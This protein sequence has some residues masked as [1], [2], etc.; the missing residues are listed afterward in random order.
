MNEKKEQGTKG[1]EKNNESQEGE[2]NVKGPRKPGYFAEKKKK[3]AKEGKRKTFGGVELGNRRARLGSV[4]EHDINQGGKH[5]KPRTEE[6]KMDGYGG[7]QKNLAI[8]GLVDRPRTVGDSTKH[9]RPT[10][11]K[12]IE[13]KRGEKRNF[14]SQRAEHNV[15]RGAPRHGRPTE[16]IW[17]RK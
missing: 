12:N 8:G 7:Q 2:K 5:K 3:R 11:G 1:E 13:K 9:Q 17:L 15:G 14:R 16:P 6:K 4:R 10:D